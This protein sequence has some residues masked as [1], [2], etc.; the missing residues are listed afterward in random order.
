MFFESVVGFI[1]S[2]TSTILIDIYNPYPNLH[3]T[4][5]YAKLYVWL[6]IGSLSDCSWF[7]LGFGLVM[8][9]FFVWFDFGGPTLE[10]FGAI[11]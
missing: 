1:Y 6:Q 4:R 5:A 11:G 3:L 2:S 7:M 9:C 8:F 10:T